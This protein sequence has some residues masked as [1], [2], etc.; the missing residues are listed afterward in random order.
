[1]DQ[2]ILR[3]VA[4]EFADLDLSTENAEIDRLKAD[5][6][7]TEDKISAAEARR[8]EIARAIYDFRGPSGRDVARALLDGRSPTDAANAGPDVPTLEREKEALHAGIRELNYLAQDLRA[9]ISAV[10]GQ[11][12]SKIAT[13][14]QLLADMIA[15]DAKA[16]IQQLV[17]IYAQ[18]AAVATTTRA[19]ANVLGKL[20]DVI[21]A[22]NGFHGFA[23]YGIKQEVPAEITRVL[24][25]LD[26]KGQA[27]KVQFLTFANT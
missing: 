7:Q 20:G 13:A 23:G 25:E 2:K 18:L 12:R 27:L 11:A 21:K 15:D 5:L 14:S 3:N 17:P 16:L 24:A 6:A 8:T 1:M 22:A 9:E 19:G 10:E 4:R 26:G